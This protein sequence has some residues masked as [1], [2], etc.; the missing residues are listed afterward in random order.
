[1]EKEKK[2]SQ[3]FIPNLENRRDIISYFLDLINIGPM[4]DI[5][6]EQVMV[7]FKKKL[8]DVGWGEDE[9]NAM[10][11]VACSKSRYM[12]DLPQMPRNRGNWLEWLG[13]RARTR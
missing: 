6:W 5:D 8:E 13:N 12:N 3:V 4:L 11:Q 2:E 1:V 7:S 9:I 10:L